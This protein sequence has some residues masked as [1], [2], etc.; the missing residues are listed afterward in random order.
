MVAVHDA[1]RPLVHPDD[2]R[3]VVSGVG[4]MAGA[5]LCARVADTV[6]RAD[7]ARMVVDTVSRADL[8]FAQTP[9][10]FRASALVDAWRTVDPS[11][12][13]TDECMLLEGAGLPVRCVLAK[14]P[15]PKLT[16]EADLALIRSLM[17]VE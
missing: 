8:Y 14:H 7:G 1:A 11:R 12:E 10:V 16:T 6:K 5:I 4:E 9:Q 2:V 13:W 17:A 15:N 3:A